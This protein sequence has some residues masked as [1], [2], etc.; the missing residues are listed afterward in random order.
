M[1]IADA[2]PG[3]K[4]DDQRE[5]RLRIDQI[6]VGELLAVERLGDLEKPP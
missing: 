1:G 2:P 6:V 3:Q 5:R 4:V